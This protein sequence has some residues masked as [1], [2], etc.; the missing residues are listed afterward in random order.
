MVIDTVGPNRLGSTLGAVRG[1]HQVLHAILL[2][3]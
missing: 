2:A 3:P 1:R